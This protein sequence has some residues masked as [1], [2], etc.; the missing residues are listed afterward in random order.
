[1]LSAPLRKV[2]ED[3]FLAEV[4]RLGESCCRPQASDIA[5]TSED[6]YSFSVH[7]SDSEVAESGCKVEALQFLSDPSHE[8]EQLKKYPVVARVFIKYNTSVPSSAP[9]ERL[10]SQAGLILTPRRNKLSDESFETLLLL[11]KNKKFA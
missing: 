10:F 6:F 2:A 8:L 9:V 5:D 7:D 1:M 4:T 3:L 11:K